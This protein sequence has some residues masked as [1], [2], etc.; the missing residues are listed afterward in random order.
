MLD[1]DS[2]SPADEASAPTDAGSDAD[3]EPNAYARAV[4]E[5]DPIAY[6][7]LDEDAGAL[8]ALD[9]VGGRK[10]F[11]V[12]DVTF[13]VPGISGAAMR[14]GATAQGLTVGTEFDFAGLQPYSFEVWAESSFSS[15]YE[16]IVAR[17]SGY[18]G[19]VVFF[20]VPPSGGTSVN[21]QHEWDGGYRGGSLDLAD[22]GAGRLLHIVVTYDPAFGLR[23]Y[24]DGRRGVRRQVPMGDRRAVPQRLSGQQPP[25][26]AR[27][28]CRLRPCALAATDCRALRARQ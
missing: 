24:V 13:G 6:W 15:E 3:A 21:V 4:L 16:N 25:R 11:P 10:A 18:S 23:L 1:E 9:V 7:P 2:E 17:R 27:R 14:F 19:Y 28:A 20:W 8:V 12:G 22:G 26:Q 5:D